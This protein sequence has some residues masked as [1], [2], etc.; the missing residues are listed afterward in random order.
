VNTLKPQ[1]F[2]NNNDNLAFQFQK[3]V[4][5]VVIMPRK[6]GERKKKNQDKS[7]SKSQ[8][9]SQGRSQGKTQCKNQKQNMDE[10]EEKKTLE[11]DD[12]QKPTKFKFICQMC[13]NCCVSENIYLSPTDI[14]RWAADNT[15]FRVMHLLDLEENEERIRISLRKDDDGKCSL[16]HRDNKRCTIYESRPIQ[17]RA[18]PLGFN[19]ENYYLKSANCKGLDKKGMNKEELEAIRNDA[20]DEHIAF[21]VSDRI[22]PIIHRIFINKLI[23]QSKDFMEKLSDAEK[24]EDTEQDK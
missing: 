2:Y 14:D 17:C 12:K 6:A 3:S 19:G 15:I 9:K 13:G 7:E 4:S 8:G 21:R 18:F 1:D 20:F 24:D 11:D 10:A 23:E 22:L 5:M 16:Y